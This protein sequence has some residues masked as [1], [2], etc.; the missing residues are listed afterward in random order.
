M[1]KKKVIGV[2]SI[3]W[4]KGSKK[5]GIPAIGLIDLEASEFV[6][7]DG[8]GKTLT[9]KDLFYKKN[10]FAFRDG[11]GSPLD[12]A[13]LNLRMVDWKALIKRFGN[14]KEKAIRSLKSKM[15]KGDHIVLLGKNGQKKLLDS[16]SSSMN[17]SN[18]VL[19][20]KSFFL[21]KSFQLLKSQLIKMS[22]S[23][24][25]PVLKNNDLENFSKGKIAL[26]RD[27]EARGLLQLL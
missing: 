17:S 18:K 7:F 3:E 9:S 2:D 27:L 11:Q 16:L 15:K 14:D 21:G 6:I 13:N 19:L 10:V 1:V 25:I 23:K 5:V 8:L 26:I 22:D 24:I 12:T 20:E 4:T